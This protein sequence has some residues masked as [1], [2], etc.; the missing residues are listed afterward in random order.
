MLRQLIVNADDYGLTAGVSRGILR[1]HREG[2]VTSTSAMVNMPPAEA[3]LQTA[4]AEAPEL[5]LGLHL[6]LTQGRPVSQPGDVSDLIRPNGTFHPREALIAQLPT[7]DTTQVERE[8]LAQVARFEQITGRLPD[9][10]DSH[11]HITYLSPPVIKLM[12]KLARELQVPIRNPLPGDAG[13]AADYLAWTLSD[14][15]TRAYTEEMV[16]IINAY[17]SRGDVVTPGRFMPGFFGEQAT[18]GDLLLMLLDVP[19]GV[20]ELMCHPAEIDDDLRQISNYVEPRQAELEALTHPSAREVINSEF[21][22]LLNF[23]DLKLFEAR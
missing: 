8:M 7:A 23:G 12:V 19:E 17:I 21:I 14:M 22:Q 20:T 18:L 6:N 10:L 16:D 2:I 11:H 9:H 13:Q 3:W 5:G 1:A 15:F 4:L